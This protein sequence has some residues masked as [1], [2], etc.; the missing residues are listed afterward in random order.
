MC[1][2]GDFVEMEEST[3][4]ATLTRLESLAWI[5][6]HKEEQKDEIKRSQMGRYSQKTAIVQGKCQYGQK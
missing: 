5:L 2:S 3:M 4:I 6:V 1:K